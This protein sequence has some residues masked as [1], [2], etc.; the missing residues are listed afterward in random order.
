MNKLSQHDSDKVILIA[1]GLAMLLGVVWLTEWV[2]AGDSL[3]LDKMLL[4]AMRDA[5]DLSSPIGPVWLEECARDITALGGVSLLSLLTLFVLSYL[6]MGGD[7]RAMAFIA[8]VAIGGLLLS[9]GLK[10]VI[11]RPRPDLVSHGT[12]VYSLSFPSAHA[13]MSAAIYYAVALL[14]RASVALKRRRINAVLSLS[15]VIILIGFSRVYLGVH[16]P[17]DVLAGWILGVLW[18]QVSL[19]VVKYL[20]TREFFHGRVI[21]ARP[22]WLIKG[23]S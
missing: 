19:L 1:L 15:V 3:A 22:V 16:W 9:F 12:Q 17:T 11:A 21:G 7:Y 10:H 5:N 14:A 8:L 20:S 13:M 2:M 4:L 18:V 6:W 23:K